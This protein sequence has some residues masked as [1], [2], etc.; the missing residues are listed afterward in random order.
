LADIFISYSKFDREKAQTLFDT[1]RAWGY[2][3]WMDT[4]GIEGAQNW[5]SEIV[6]GINECQTLILLLS[7]TSVASRNVMR[8]VH[9][10]S[11]KHKNILPIMLENVEIPVILEYPLAGLQRLRYEHT[12]SISKALQSLA[13][14]GSIHMPELKAGAG[15][16]TKD[17]FVHLAVLPFQDI[18]AGHENEWFADGMTEELI[19][20]L[21]KLERM[22]V[23]GRNDILFYKTHR[24]KSKDIA[25]DLGVRYLVEGSVRKHGNKIRIMTS[26]SDA[27]ENQQLWSEKYDGE[28]DDV[29]DLQ[30]SVAK[31]IAQALEIKLTPNDI[32]VIDA[33]PT[34]NAEAYECYLR[35]LEQQ[36][37]LTRT[38]YEAALELYEKAVAHDPK[39]T[40]AYLSVAHTSGAY[41][42]ELSR[43]PKWL[44]RANANLAKAE[45][46][47][48][49]TAKTLWIH[50]EL[51]WLR[52]ELDAAEKILLKATERDPKFFPA[53]DMLGHVLFQQERYFAAAAAFQKVLDEMPSNATAHYNMMLS[54]SKLPDKIVL[55]EKAEVA[56]GVL[57]KRL[58]TRSQDSDFVINYVYLLFW[59]GREKEVRKNI[60]S[61]LQ[62][63][64][65]DPFVLYN[66]GCMYDDLGE[67]EKY[68][69]ITRMAIDRGFRAIE[70]LKSMHFTNPILQEK[71]E[72]LIRDLEALIEKERNG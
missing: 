63:K 57:E 62:D 1:I 34:E 61:M 67:P 22:K 6:E 5:S 41:Y 68:I 23:P 59:S 52:G 29:F 18:S 8:E 38:G 20:T 4:V 55:K 10:A 65:L 71:L 28:F 30:D 56:L 58:N 14:G 15:K 26:V 12:S 31:Q 40:E 7:A 17:N 50:G 46:I 54:Y 13:I 35:G 47:T 19:S 69:E 66:M 45:A 53:H 16:K 64:T 43:S 24:P 33:R 36:R 37:K 2:S 49:E 27:W 3:V 9:L 70:G 51:A 72:V 42:R 32:A 11:E 25:E 39:F 48:G 44:E 60:D 21:G